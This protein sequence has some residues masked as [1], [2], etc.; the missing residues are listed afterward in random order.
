MKISSAVLLIALAACSQSSEVRIDV[1]SLRQQAAL[2]GFDLDVLAIHVSADD[3]PEQ[4]YALADNETSLQLSLTSGPAR[5]FEVEATTAWPVDGTQVPAFYG[6]TVR[7]L[8]AGNVEVTI[9]TLRVGVV[10][11]LVRPASESVRGASADILASGIN[12]RLVADGTTQRI[13]APIGTFNVTNA[14]SDLDVLVDGSVDVAQGAVSSALAFIVARGERCAPDAIREVKAVA[15]A[16][17]EIA[18]LVSGVAGVSVQVELRDAD[19]RLLETQTSVDG[20]VVIFA[21]GIPRGAGYSVSI[22]QGSVTGGGECSITGSGLI[23]GV[24]QPAVLQCSGTPPSGPQ[25]VQPYFANSD[26]SRYFVDESGRASAEC[27]ASTP[28]LGCA[29]AAESFY[30]ALPDISDCAGGS[31]TDALGLLKWRCEDDAAPGVYVRSYAFEPATNNYFLRRALDFATTPP[32]FVQNTLTV[33]TSQGN[34]TTPPSRWWTNPVVDANDGTP[35][36]NA[37]V[38]VSDDDPVSIIGVSHV[39][40]VTRPAVRPTFVLQNGAFAWIEGE[41]GGS[42]SVMSVDVV[43]YDFIQMRGVSTH[44][45]WVFIAADNGFILRDSELESQDTGITLTVQN[46]LLENV[47]VIAAQTAGVEFQNQGPHTMRDSRVENVTSTGI[48]LGSG[49][50]E[51]LLERVTSNNTGGYGIHVD[52]DYGATVLKDITL[53]NNPHGL[54]V[55]SV[56]NLRVTGLT[57]SGSSS[58]HIDLQTVRGSVFQNVTLT[59]SDVGINVASSTGNFFSGLIVR[60]SNVGIVLQSASNNNTFNDLALIDNT[61]GIAAT[62]G[63]NHTSGQLYLSG[64][65]TGCTSNASPAFTHFQTGNCTDAGTE[66]SSSYPGPAAGATLRLSTIPFPFV[67]FLG[68]DD[69]ANPTDVPGG[70]TIPPGANF[71]AFSNHYRGFAVEGSRSP[72]AVGSYCQVLDL[73]LTAGTTMAAA[74]TPTAYRH[75]WTTPSAAASQLDCSMMAPGS[76]YLSNTCYTDFVLGAYEAGDANNR[77]GLCTSGETC[78]AGVNMGSFPGDGA[79]L[80]G[81]AVPVGIGSATVRPYTAASV[82]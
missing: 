77:D 7:D 57:A 34:R 3:I 41:I 49:A 25:Q 44:G 65:A 53:F 11:L 13:T 14:D 36:S 26:W 82:L 47:H 2:G 33:V 42:S 40:I 56:N 63:P 67:G 45:G 81:T 10:D 24:S 29:H 27:Q 30:L 52:S 50:G 71:T 31:A 58:N 51:V 6:V 78:N 1:S 18:L 23:A 55:S 12:G 74:R 17:Q 59:G 79:L 32:T 19:G 61:T 4:V 8:P 70:V 64:N 62:G 38:V 48:T 35:P 60:E 46:S 20:A 9:E 66:G 75:I 80:I 69:P 5:R 54:Y 73:R 72:C 28:P 22:V 16:C 39:S 68:N 76:T 37:I 21:Y 15:P 43:Q